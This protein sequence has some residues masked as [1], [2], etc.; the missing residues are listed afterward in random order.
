M[1]GPGEKMILAQTLSPAGRMIHL[2]VTRSTN[3]KKATESFLGSVVR[4]STTPTTPTPQSTR[5]F[6]MIY[7]V[8]QVSANSP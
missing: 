7:A 2:L 1:P 8:R 5:Y 3:S 6:L 4:Y